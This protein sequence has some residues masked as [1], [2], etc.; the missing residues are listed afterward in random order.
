MAKVAK[1]LLTWNPSISSDVTSQKLVVTV[2]G[3]PSLDLSLPSS[4]SDLLITI[5]EKSLVHIELTAFDGTYYSE[6]ATLDFTV[7]DLTNPAPPTGFNY[8]IIEIVDGDAVEVS[9]HPIGLGQ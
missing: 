5:T 2:N 8:E 6:P 9:D 4:A 1:I 3:E 7:G